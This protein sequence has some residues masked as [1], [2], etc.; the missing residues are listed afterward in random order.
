ME[1]IKIEAYPSN[2]LEK[3]PAIKRIPGK[4]VAKTPGFFERVLGA[5]KDEIGEYVIWD[6]LIPSI[7]STISDIISNGIEMILYG[8]PRR[9][10]RD[11]DRD[12]VGS[13]ISYT[14]YYDRGERE[15]DRD[16]RQTRPIKRYDVDDVV[17]DTRQD[18]EDVISQLVDLISQYGVVTVA[19]LYDIVGFPDEYP[20]NKYGWTNLSGAGYRH[21]REGYILE[22]PRP[23]ALD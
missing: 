6:I 17:L 22:L 23:V 13:R 5:H 4:V 11:R 2:S 10:G 15:H 18:C 7:K 9:G 3:K 19:N 20:D 16:R 12:R 1:E 8:E 21:V 14:K